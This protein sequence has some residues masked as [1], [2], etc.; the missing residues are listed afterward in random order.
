M[1][2]KTVFAVMT[3]T[4]LTEG[5]GTQYYKY[6]CDLEATAQ[7]L[8]RGNYVMGTDCPIEVINLHKIEDDVK[9]YGPVVLTRPS[10]DDIEKEKQ[11]A[12]ERIMKEKRKELLKKMRESGFSDDEIS[13]LTKS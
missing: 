7:R 8:A 4:D 10:L 3:N 5:R 11:F 2:T 9:W 12:H 6:Y 1:K 13:I